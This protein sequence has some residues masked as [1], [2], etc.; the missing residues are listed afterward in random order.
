M[1]GGTR[2]RASEARARRRP[3]RPA[4]RAATPARQP[5]GRGAQCERAH[6]R[7][8]CA[9]AA[10]PRSFLM[11]DERGA[12]VGRAPNADR[13]PLARACATRRVRRRRT[14]A[15]RVRVCADCRHG[16]GRA[17]VVRARWRASRLRARVRVRDCGRAHEAVGLGCAFMCVRCMCESRAVACFA[18]ARAR[19]LGAAVGS[20]APPRPGSLA[21]RC[22]G[23]V[24]RGRV[25]CLCAGNCSH[26]CAAW[27][28]TRRACG[29]GAPGLGGRGGV[30]G[31]GGARGARVHRHAHKATPGLRP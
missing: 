3:A 17:G 29:L 16:G 2:T 8:H 25:A 6:S 23:W 5:A 20:P 18:L 30:R 12:D 14:S 27:R 28:V 21:A 10:R 22:A 1:A 19:G 11:Q 31:G 9:G 7:G 24:R 13:A 26:G 15:A 4:A